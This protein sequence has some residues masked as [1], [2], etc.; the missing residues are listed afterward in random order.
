MGK[1]CRFGPNWCGPVCVGG[2]SC[3]SKT[4]CRHLPLA[5]TKELV[6]RHTWGGIHLRDTLA[7]RTCHHRC[8]YPAGWGNECAVGWP[9]SHISPPAGRAIC[10]KLPPPFLPWVSSLRRTFAAVAASSQ[11]S[12]TH[13]KMPAVFL[14]DLALGAMALH[15]CFRCH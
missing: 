9:C 14:K 11:G 3:R 4:L 15:K 12:V 7:P 8:K 6:E 13:L 10:H 2:G 1:G 5:L